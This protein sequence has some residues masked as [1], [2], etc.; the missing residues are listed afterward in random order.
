MRAALVAALIAPAALAADPRFVWETMETPRFLV[1]YHQGSHALAA[2][3]ARMAELAHKKLAPLLD[4]EPAE[5]CHVVLSDDTDFANGSATPLLRNTI[6]LYAPPPDARSTLNDFDDYVWELVSHEYTHILHLD[7]VKG[8]PDFANAVFGKLWI[9]NG[10]QPRW[11][12]EGIATFAESELSASGRI[13]SSGEE[14]AVR[15]Q[16]LGGTFPTISQLSNL[17]LDWPRGDAWY[18]IGGRFLDFISDRWGLGALRDLS[19]DYGG[20]VIPFGLNF[21]A[22]SVVG[23]SYLELYEEFRR[24]EKERAQEAVTA[25]REGGETAFEALTELGER[26]RSPRFSR[27]GRTL[28]YTSAGPHRLPELRALDLASRADRRLAESFGDVSLGVAPDGRIVYARPQ[29][30]QRWHDIEDLYALDPANGRGERLTRGLRAGE[31]D[32]APDGTLVFVWRR[33]GG[34]TAIAELAPGAAGPRV[35]FEDPAVGPVGS[36]RVSPDGAQ[37]AFTHHRNGSWDVRIVSR[38]DGAVSDVT[39]DRSIDRDPAWSPDGRFLLF[40]SDRTGV[41]D[42]YAHRFADQASLRVTRV[43][44]GAFEPAVSPDMKQL[45]FVSYSARGYDLARIPFAPEAWPAAPKPVAADERPRP[46]QEPPRELFPARAYQPLETL[47]P[48]FW[49]PIAAADALGTTL[50]VL[51]AGSDVVGRHEYAAT[52]WWGLESRQPGWAFSYTSRAQIP[53]ITLSASRDVVDVAGLD[54]TDI[55][56]TQREVRGAVQAD[57]AFPNLERSFALRIGYEVSKLANGPLPLGVVPL[58][59]VVA[60]AFG[61]VSYSDA[62]RFVR[63]ISTE[64]GRR[65][66]LTLRVADRALG[67]DFGF[68]T[69]TAAVAQFVPLPWSRHHVLALRAAAGA[70]FGDLG[71][72][73]QFSLGGFGATDA[74]RAILNP[75]AAPVRVLRG[76]RRSSFSGDA[77]VLGT[78]E[79]R[80]PVADVQVGAWTL[81]LYLRRLHAAAFAD[82]GDAFDVG[83]GAR[84]SRRFTL[85]AGAGLEA[86]AELVLGYI[87]P[88]DLRLGCARGIEDSREAV[89]DCYLALGGIF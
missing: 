86:R 18:A 33:P 49:L 85:H 79:I 26:T 39:G 14:M 20:R 56:P 53:D 64:T 16:A 58:E 45:A 19:H 28:Y 73:R 34:R 10:A 83:P 60:S 75:A 63:S 21:S 59:G 25:V 80:V 47:R 55:C 2:R 36:P 74:L 9:P 54:C 87:L 35:L 81:P 17:P 27:D 6:R 69:I 30:Y 40:S 84:A 48:Y 43:A 11:F 24:Q 61:S 77:Y 41:F 1:H 7:T 71:E 31:P 89:L 5:R 23:K 76:F 78:A 37:V 12:I 38:R 66:S 57:F 29:I 51:T 82:V 88:T 68:Q 65:A 46:V 50:G 72:Q 62:R 8:L 4:R 32:V 70:G 22:E 67:S 15:A 3:V 52:A 44:M 13:R 42:L